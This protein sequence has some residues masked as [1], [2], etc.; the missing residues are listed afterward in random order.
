MWTPY[1]PDNRKFS[2]TTHDCYKNHI[3][4]SALGLNKG[5]VIYDHNMI[6]KEVMEYLDYEQGVDFLFHA[7]FPDFEYPMLFSSQYRFRDADP[8][9]LYQDIC[10]TERN[11]ESGESG[12][13]YKLLAL[14]FVYGYVNRTTHRLVEAIVTDCQKMRNCIINGTLRPKDKKPIN[15]RTN[16]P[17]LCYP[18]DE[19]KRLGLVLLHWKDV[20][21]KICRQSVIIDPPSLESHPYFQKDEN[22]A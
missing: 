1:S 6:P 5:D 22:I 2:D 18:F 7:K 4:P 3:Y 16:Q 21:G 15:P 9:Q 12:E 20:N 19:L 13:L 10:L 8:F 11:D 14:L 17:M